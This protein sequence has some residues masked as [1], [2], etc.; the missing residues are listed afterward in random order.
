MKKNYYDWLEVSKHASPE[1]IEKAYKTLVKKYHPDL[2]ENSQK[3]KSE[4]I[5]K[6]L[7]AAYE[8]LSDPEKRKNYDISIQEKPKVSNQQTT[9]YAQNITPKKEEPKIKYKKTKKEYQKDLIAFILTIL[10]LLIICQI[11]FVKKIIIDFY[12]NN[13]AFHGIIDFFLK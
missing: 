3:N 10:F 12:N 4:E 13:T 5:L 2:Q 9:I 6:K 1:I 11:P 7:N 8:I